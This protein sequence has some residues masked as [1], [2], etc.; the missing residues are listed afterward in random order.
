VE[1]QLNRDRAALQT[2]KHSHQDIPL[3]LQAVVWVNY[4]QFFGTLDVFHPFYLLVLD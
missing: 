1:G 4:K 3:G 2:E